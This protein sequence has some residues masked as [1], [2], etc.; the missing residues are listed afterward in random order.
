[1]SIS[2]SK[3]IAAGFAML[4]FIILLV[5][6]I[7]T[8]LVPSWLEQ[9]AQFGSERPLIVI[10]Y[11]GNM[12]PGAILGLL[13]MLAFVIFQL[14]VRI[15]GKVALSLVNKVNSFTGKA[16]VASLVATF[17]GS[18]ALGYWLDNKAEHAGYQ[19]C[20]MFTLL[21]NRVTYTAW[22][23]NEALCYDNDVRRIVSRGTIDEAIQVEQHLQQRLKQQAAKLL[24]LEQEDALRRARD[25]KK[26]AN[27]S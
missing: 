21:S 15:R 25:A 18:F 16:M 24:F 4:F 19:P 23:Q 12:M 7:I 13:V 8:L 1:M 3:A 5:I 11:S 6:A 2:N 17:A 26:A 14:T 20:P 10:S 22:V 9:L 27:G